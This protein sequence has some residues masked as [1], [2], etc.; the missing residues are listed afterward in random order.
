MRNLV[1]AV[2]V[3]RPVEGSFQVWSRGGRRLRGV[4]SILALL[5]QGARAPGGAVRGSGA[6]VGGRR[7]S[8]PYQ[9]KSGKTPV[10]RAELLN[11]HPA[12]GLGANGPKQ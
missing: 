3:R 10:G 7:V 6:A 9:V 11:L 8:Y 5:G 2:C 12:L 1:G 4:L